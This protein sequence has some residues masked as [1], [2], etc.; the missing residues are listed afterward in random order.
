MDMSAPYR[1]VVPTLDGPVL[2]VLASTNQGLTMRDVARLVPKGS[3]A[4]V[5]H[6]LLRLETQ[7][8]ALSQQAGSSILFSLNRNHLAYPAVEVLVNMRRALIEKLRAVL[9]TWNTPPAHA[10]LFGS[11]ARGDGDEHSDIDIYI[12]R[13]ATVDEQDEPWRE[14]LVALAMEVKSWTGNRPSLV[15]TSENE[16]RK[17]LRSAKRLTNDISNEGIHLAGPPLHDLTRAHR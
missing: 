11:T 10:S 5:R 9:D 6:A 1:T 8:I 16:A 12:V 17:S 14:Q 3:F 7:G 2:A 15:E 13:P 4:G